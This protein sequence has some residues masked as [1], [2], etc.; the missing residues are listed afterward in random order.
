[1]R[2]LVPLVA[3]LGF[4]TGCTITLCEGVDL[5]WSDDRY[6]C[7]VDVSE[8]LDDPSFECVRKF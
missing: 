6:E 5:S 2:G 1:M 8:K 7:D 3:L 4:L